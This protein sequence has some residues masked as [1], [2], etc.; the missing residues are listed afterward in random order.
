MVRQ[1]APACVV[2]LSKSFLTHVFARVIR[3]HHARHRPSLTSITARTHTA[4]PDGQKADEEEGEEA[5]EN[6][7]SWWRY[8]RFVRHCRGSREVRP[9]P[10]TL[11]RQHDR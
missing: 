3:T 2:A 11:P 8:S 1:L 6:G 7:S 5:Q 4:C 10:I 9:P